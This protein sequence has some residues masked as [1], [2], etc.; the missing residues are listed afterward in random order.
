MLDGIRQL[1]NIYPMLSVLGFSNLAEVDYQY[2]KRTID[3]WAIFDGMFISSS[4][5]SRK[6]DTVCYT[7]FI[8]RFELD[9]KSC[10]FVDDRLENVIAAQ[11]LGMRCVLFDNTKTTITMLHNLLGDPVERGM[12]FLRENAQSHFCETSTG[13]RHRDNYSQLLILESTGD[14]YVRGKRKAKAAELSRSLVRLVN[15]GPTWSYL[16]GA[17]EITGTVYPDDSDTTSLAMVC[18][19]DKS[20]PRFCHCICASVFRFFYLHGWGDK[21]PGTCAYLCSVLRSSAHLFGTRYYDNPDWIF[22]S[23]IDVCAKR[24]SDEGLKELRSLLRTR[25]QERMGCDRNPL[26]A[27]LRLVA[28]QGLEMQNPRDLNTLLET[29]QVDGGWERVWLWRYGKE[30]VK[31]GSRGVITALAIKVE[32]SL[33]LDGYHRY[34]SGPI[35]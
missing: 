5:G 21:L 2:L 24:P 25:L 15:D 32:F 9:G 8:E 20:R 1:K 3:E 28:A 18:W 29:Q 11:C 17:S 31:I 35:H 10:I 12:A 6:P 7:R 13:I 27:A 23:L 34:R 33:A 14:R 26:G 19:F 16:V 30:G 22:Y 4:S